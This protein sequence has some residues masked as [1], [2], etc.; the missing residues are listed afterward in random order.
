MNDSVPLEKAAPLYV[1]E[2]MK[3]CDKAKQSSFR[4]RSPPI[5]FYRWDLVACGSSADSPGG[6]CYLVGYCAILSISEYF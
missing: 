6:R 3:L 5:D 1:S 2:I 4:N